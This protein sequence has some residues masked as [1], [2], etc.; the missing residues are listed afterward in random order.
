MHVSEQLPRVPVSTSI[1][2][3]RTVVQVDF[4]FVDLYVH[5][6]ACQFKPAGV[7]LPDVFQ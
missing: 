1:A 6:Q 3:E 4:L 7:P 5:L 2:E